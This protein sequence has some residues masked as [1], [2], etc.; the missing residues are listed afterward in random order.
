MGIVV[1]RPPPRI[2][3]AKRQYLLTKQ[4]LP[5]WLCRAHQQSLCA[6]CYSERDRIAMQMHEGSLHGTWRTRPLWICLTRT[7]KNCTLSGMSSMHHHT[8]DLCLPELRTLT[9]HLLE[10]RMTREKYSS[11]SADSSSVCFV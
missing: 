6:R 2:C 4:I 5:F 11:F 3:T 8:C 10:T 1:K 9:P 7:L